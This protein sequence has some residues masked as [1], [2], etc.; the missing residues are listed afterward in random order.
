MT[1]EPKRTM[2]RTPTHPGEILK[3]EF[4]DE[5]KITPAELADHID[6]PLFLIEGLI[7]GKQRMTAELA[8]RVARAFGTSVEFWTN[9]QAKVDEYDARN[10][11]TIGIERLPCV[12]KSKELDDCRFPHS[13]GDSD[14]PTAKELEEIIEDIRRTYEPPDDCVWP[15]PSDD[16]DPFVPWD[17]IPKYKPYSPSTDDDDWDKKYGGSYIVTCDSAS[18]NKSSSM[19]QD[20]LDEAIELKCY[21]TIGIG[22]WPND[23]TDA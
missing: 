6:C 4:L 18:S 3:F 22:V 1:F 23:K 10:V 9:L 7:K 16:T 14:S 15:K 5:Y 19:Y 12:E 17:Q 2:T 20:M 21:Q 13:P 11:S 8:A